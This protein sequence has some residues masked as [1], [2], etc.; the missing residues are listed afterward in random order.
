[1]NRQV[2]HPDPVFTANEVED[3]FKKAAEFHREAAAN[4]L[5]DPVTYFK[6]AYVG[7]NPK[8]AAAILEKIA[9]DFDFTASQTQA[10]L[11][12]YASK[13]LQCQLAEEPK[14]KSQEAAAS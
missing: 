4:I 9:R 11:T 14:E 12:I 10:Q 5:S 1:M 7:D 2:A 6:P 8:E 13:R 3:C